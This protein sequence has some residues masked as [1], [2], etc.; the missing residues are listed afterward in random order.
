M[1]ALEV[2]GNGPEGT[3]IP[4]NPS[5]IPAQVVKNRPFLWR[6]TGWHWSL[7]F[8]VVP[9]KRFT[10]LAVAKRF[11]AAG[12]ARGEPGANIAVGKAVLNIGSTNELIKKARVKTVACPDGIDGL[13]GERSSME[14]VFAAFRDCALRTAFD[15]NDR[16]DP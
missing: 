3:A 1:T 9:Q 4:M 16:N 8:L 15:D 12:A 14:S 10:V 6:Q 11:G 13:N 7:S 5:S 2:R